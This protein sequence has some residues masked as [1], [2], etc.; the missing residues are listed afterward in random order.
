[1]AR[2]PITSFLSH[3]LLL[4]LRGQLLKRAADPLGAGVERQRRLVTGS[5]FLE[6]A[7]GGQGQTHVEVR[8]G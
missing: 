8:G 3:L 2:S 7:L 6:V 5:G 1:M 4:G